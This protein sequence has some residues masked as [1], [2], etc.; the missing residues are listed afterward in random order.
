[1]DDRIHILLAITDSYAAYCAVTLVSMFENNK[2]SNFCVHIICTDLTDN[3]RGQLE[4]IF[5]CYKQK[6]D[7]IQPD[8]TKFQP[9]M[10]VKDR[11]PNKYHV[12]AYYRLFA[13]EWLSENIDR[14][15]YLD[16]DLIVVGDIKSLWKEHL[17]NNTA[18]CATH[19]FIRI[20]DYHRLQINP[21]LH[22]YFNSGVLLINLSY[23]RLHSIGQRCV[24]YLCTYPE[25]ILIA[26]Q[27]ALNAVLVGKVKYIHP[28]Y[29]TMSF[30]FAKEEYLSI[31]TWYSDMNMIR[32]AIKEPVIVHFAGEKPW[33]KGDYLP[34]RDEWMKYLNMTEWKSMKIGYKR[35]W[36]GRYKQL[37]QKIAY[38]IL[39]KIGK[40]LRLSYP[41][42]P[43]KTK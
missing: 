18:L 32:E 17:D 24:D 2:G 23:W 11:M 13:T 10:D 42:S 33:F 19:D 34:Y 15:I 39:G 8:L 26:D 21:M 9:I 35:G 30:Y 31:C 36:K 27:E 14:V 29:N 16:C 37:K 25:R 22:T 43:Y 12:S 5:Q 28:K 41:V 7:W 1:M 40:S 4:R 38:S 3:N 20:N 6:V